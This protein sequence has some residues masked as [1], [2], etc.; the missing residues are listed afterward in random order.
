MFLYFLHL[1]ISNKNLCNLLSYEKTP[2]KCHLIYF[3]PF[4]H[5]SQVDV[6]KIL[7]LIMIFVNNYFY[8][9]KISFFLHF[10]TKLE[11][12]TKD[13]SA[14]PQKMERDFSRLLQC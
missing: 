14:R 1:K 5:S 2:K 7:V 10:W 13:K 11:Q 6:A 4:L 3:A 9:F 12:N 8:N